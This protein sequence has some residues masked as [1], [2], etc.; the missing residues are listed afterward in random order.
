MDQIIA[1]AAIAEI[2]EMN[3]KIKSME[4]MQRRDIAKELYDGEG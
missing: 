4:E 1:D 3:R 2:R